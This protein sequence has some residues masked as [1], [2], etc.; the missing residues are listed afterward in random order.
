MKSELAAKDAHF[1]NAV[2]YFEFLKIFSSR[3]VV[4]EGSKKLVIAF[5]NVVAPKGAV[6]D[7]KRSALMLVLRGFGGP[8]ECPWA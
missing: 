5:I 3:V 4:L 8:T 1:V 2:L 7:L 6:C